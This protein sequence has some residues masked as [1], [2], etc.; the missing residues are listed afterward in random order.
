MSEARGQQVLPLDLFLIIRPTVIDIMRVPVVFAVF[1]LANLCF[2]DIKT[3]TT[4]GKGKKTRC[5]VINKIN[6]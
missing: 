4:E 6:K 1:P 2:Q 5:N 3:V